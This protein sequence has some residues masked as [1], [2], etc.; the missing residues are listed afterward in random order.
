[1]L[2][3]CNQVSYTLGILTNEDIIMNRQI[4]YRRVSTSHLNQSTDRQLFDTGITF[5]LEFE[6]HQ[7]ASSAL[8]RKDF[9]TLLSIVE[10]TDTIHIQSNDRCFRNVRE[11]LGF[12]EDMVAKEVT[13]KLHTEK[14]EFSAHGD[15]M[16]VAQ[17]KLMLTQLASFSEFFL[18]QN[19]IAIKQGITRAKSKGV[20]FGAANEKYQL[21]SKN[22]TRINRRDGITRTEHLKEPLTLIISMLSKPTYQRIADK[23][24]EMEYALPSGD[25]KPWTASQAKRVCDRLEISR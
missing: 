11:M 13:V 22:A 25:I 20:K 14:L 5:D 7:S 18:T 24:T 6:D 1:M 9:Q 3:V 23:L 19:K 17:S 12:V 16:Q 15:P 8:A 21:N 2:D 10:A 4:A